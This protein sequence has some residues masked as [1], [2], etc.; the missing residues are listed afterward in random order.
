MIPTQLYDIFRRSTGVT[1]D[2][3]HI[4]QGAMFF[5]LRGETFDG[6]TFAAQALEKG[7]SCAVVSDEQIIPSTYVAYQH[8]SYPDGTPSATFYAQ[9][10]APHV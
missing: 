7:A 6:N 2:T 3:R 10:T 9:P 4:E 1:T 5:A 8:P